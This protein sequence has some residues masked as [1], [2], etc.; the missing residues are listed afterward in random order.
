MSDQAEI[1]TGKVIASCVGVAPADVEGSEAEGLKT[2]AAVSP[3]G[4]SSLKPRLKSLRIPFR[5]LLLAGASVGVVT[6][7]SLCLASNYLNVVVR[8]TRD[9]YVLYRLAGERDELKATKNRLEKELAISSIRSKG[10]KGSME[11]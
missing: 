7:L 1:R 8:Q 10:G 4:T 6:G 3:G 9:A 2:T 11:V 5:W